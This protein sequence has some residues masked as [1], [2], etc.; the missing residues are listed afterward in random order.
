MMKLIDDFV[1]W[2]AKEKRINIGARLW[3]LKRGLKNMH[4]SRQNMQS[5]RQMLPNVR[6]NMNVNA[7]IPN[8]KQRSILL[9]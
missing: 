1:K 7:A 4:R 3:N 2:S 8:A 9:G 6:Q 5:A